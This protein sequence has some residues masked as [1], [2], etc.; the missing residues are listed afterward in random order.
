MCLPSPDGAP[1]PDAVESIG[2]LIERSTS[3]NIT[4]LGTHVQTIHMCYVVKLCFLLGLK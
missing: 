4:N 2:N 1:D 3:L